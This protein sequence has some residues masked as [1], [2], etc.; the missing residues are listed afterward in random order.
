MQSRDPP[1]CLAFVIFYLVVFLR[2]HLMCLR[3]SIKF[4]IQFGCF[5]IQNKH[6]E[7]YIFLSDET[8]LYAF[9][10]LVRSEVEKKFPTF[11]EEDIF[12][13][14]HKYFLCW[15][16]HRNFLYHHLPEH[17][18]IRNILNVLLIF[19]YFMLL[20]RHIKNNFWCFQI[21]CCVINVSHKYMY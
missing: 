13:Q 20:S 11:G 10:M 18:I 4:L 14:Q 1:F 19:S 9:M 12:F 17:W 5:V 16:H 8:T 7:K 15:H 3:K 6:S 2:E 21:L